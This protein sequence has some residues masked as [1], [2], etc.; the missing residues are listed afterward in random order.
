MDEQTYIQSVRSIQQQ[1]EMPVELTLSDNDAQVD[2]GHIHAFDNRL[3]VASGTIRARAI[4]ENTDGALI[5]G[6]YAN[7]SLGSANTHASLLVPDRAIGTNQNRKFVYVVDAQNAVQYREVVL[8]DHFQAHR[9]IVS[10]LEAGE[11]IAVNS[12]SHLRPSTVIN[13]VTVNTL[14]QLAA[15]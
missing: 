2:H 13:P 6:M 7:I 11:R 14:N 15:Q 4:F 5:P 10:G 8:G 9:V 1:E 3:D 12:L